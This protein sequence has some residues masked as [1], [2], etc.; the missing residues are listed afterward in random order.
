MLPGSLVFNI[1]VQ[2]ISRVCVPPPQDA[3][4]LLNGL[5][6][7]HAYVYSGGIS[8]HNLSLLPLQ[9][10]VSFW[11]GKQTEHTLQTP[12]LKKRPA[13]HD[14]HFAAP[15]VAQALPCAPAPPLQVH[16]FTAHCLSV[17]PVPADDSYSVLASQVL[18]GLHDDWPKGRK[19]SA[20]QGH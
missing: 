12:L 17:V 11:P 5:G 7:L 13:L 4:H 14:T 2:T 16:F 9:V 15:F 8:S 6:V 20:W 1:L 18:Q 19:C 3:E 10:L